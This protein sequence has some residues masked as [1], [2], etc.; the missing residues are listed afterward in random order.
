MEINRKNIVKRT[1]YYMEQRKGYIVDSHRDPVLIQRMM[2]QALVALGEICIVDD[3]GRYLYVSDEYAKSMDVSIEDA[4]G[5]PISEFIDNTDIPNVLKTGRPTKGVIY[6]RNGRSFWLNRFPIK[7]D[8]KIIGAVGQAMMTDDQELDRLRSQL[9]SLV[10]ELN[11]Y[12]EKYRQSAGKRHSVSSVITRSEGMLAL[13][14]TLFTVA[15]TRS[16]VLLTGESGT[17]KEV[18]ANAI[19]DLSPRKDKPFVKLNCA[20]IPDHLLEAELF[21]YE[22]GSF[23]GALKGGKIGDFEAADGGTILLDEVDSLTPGMQSKLLRVIQER[24][25]KKVGSTKPTPVDV[26]FIFATNKNLFKLVKDGQFREDFYYR[27]N[28]ISLELPPLRERLEDIP[29]LAEHFIRKLNAELD[30]EIKGMTPEA[31]SLLESYQWPGNIRE[32]EN[33]MERAFN[34]AQGDLLKAEYFHL[35][36]AD[37]TQKLVSMTLKNIRQRAEETAIKRA[38][39]ITN[40]NKKEAAELLEI[41]RSLLYD[42]I[43]LYGI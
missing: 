1:W 38:L 6:R 25:V 18:F 28:V 37:G 41:D 24:E 36:V 5:K 12:K 9:G 10:K 13:K 14:E 42:K 27:I 35:P 19:H 23:T 15:R 17:G 20:A 34:F 32:L 31:L 7:E 16:T 11:Y 39:K 4:M 30:M 22:E 2:E 33:Y 43:K 29:L 26:R 3:A 40:G 21:G 8:G